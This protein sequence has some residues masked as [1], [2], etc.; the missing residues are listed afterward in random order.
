VDADGDGQTVADL[1]LAE[2]VGSE[3]GHAGAAGDIVLPFVEGQKSVRNF[4]RLLSPA[5]SG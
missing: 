4:S 5:A 2:A 1:K 3:H